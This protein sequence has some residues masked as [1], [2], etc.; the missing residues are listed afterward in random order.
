MEVEVRDVSHLHVAGGLAER[1]ATQVTCEGAR[2]DR[3]LG[4]HLRG[5][6]RIAVR[7]VVRVGPRARINWAL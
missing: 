1:Q 4:V 2:V 7:A 5:G 6:S 3:M